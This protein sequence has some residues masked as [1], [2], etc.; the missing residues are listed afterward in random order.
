MEALKLYDSMVFN[1]E[2]IMRDF[3]GVVFLAYY[4]YGW[5][6]SIWESNFFREFKT[7][8]GIWRIMSWEQQ[9]SVKEVMKRVIY[10][11]T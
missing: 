2:L 5:K 10:R 3:L 7:W 1:M 4:I 8:D 6:E 11:Y 9:T